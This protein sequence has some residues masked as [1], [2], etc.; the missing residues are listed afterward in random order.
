MIIAVKYVKDAPTFFAERLHKS[1]SGA[2]TDDTA[3]IRLIVTRSEVRYFRIVILVLPLANHNS[4]HFRGSLNE[5]C[6]GRSLVGTVHGEF[7][8]YC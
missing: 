3:L 1:M 4:R 6:C 7:A 5:K 8:C 2:G